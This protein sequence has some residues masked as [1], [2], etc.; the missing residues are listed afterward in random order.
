MVSPHRSTAE[1][2]AVGATAEEVRRAMLARIGS[3]AWRPGERLSP[4][5]ELAVQMSVSRGTLRQALAALEEVG[6]LRRVPGRGG[7]TFV[8]SAKVERNP[9]SL[10]GVPALLRSQGMVAGTRVLSAAVE[11]ANPQ[12]AGE[13]DL[14][15]GALVFRVLRVRLADGSP[16]SLEEAQ[17][18][19]HRFPGLLELPLGE[20][21]YELLDAHYGVRPG[22]AVERMEVVTASPSEALV[23]DV[24]PG[25]PLISILRTT[26]DH[27]GEPIEY[28]FDLFRGDRTRLVVRSDGRQGVSTFGTGRIVELRSKTG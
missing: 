5:R 4:E 25:A 17:L 16:L 23:L 6:A 15:E 1:F 13:L 24:Q 28:S 2:S 14:T 27:G 7:G 9:S 8:A 22:Q 21:V 20:S 26:L 19:A 18:P 12:V 10:I 3:G 11:V